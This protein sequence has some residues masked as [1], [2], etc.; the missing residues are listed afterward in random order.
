MKIISLGYTC[1]IKNLI[2]ETGYS[3]EHDIFDWINSF[4]FTKIIT[5]IENKFNIFENIIKSPVNVDLKSSGNVY[6]SEQYCFRFPHEINLNKSKETYSRRFERFINYK[7]D[8]DNYLFIRMINFGRYDIKEENLENNYNDKNYLK[9]MSYLPK[10][11]KIL[12]ITD[13]KLSLNDKKNISN[14]FYIIDN[15]ISPDHIA[16]GDYLQYRQNIIHN[17]K[18]MFNYINNNFDNFDTE[19]VQ[20]FINNSGPVVSKINL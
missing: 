4:E 18:N 12:L 3:K 17:Y 15:I 19:I 6:F 10:K 5:S 13:K 1:Y 9:I 16:Y 20:N 2:N 8:L 7:N 11:S 14:N